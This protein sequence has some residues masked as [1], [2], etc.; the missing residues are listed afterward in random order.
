MGKK[1]TRTLAMRF[2][3]K[4]ERRD[5]DECWLWKGATNRAGYGLIKETATD[6]SRRRRDLRAHRVACMLVN[7]PVASDVVICHKCDRPLCVNPNHLLAGSH[8]DNV[9]DCIAKGRKRVALGENAGKTKLKSEDIPRIF[10]FHA[11]GVTL[12][13]IAQAFGVRHQSIQHILVGRSWRHV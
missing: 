8:A 2:W 3:E 7:G 1:I 4:V 9:A 5:P 6:S 13:A 12:R 10:A 11:Q